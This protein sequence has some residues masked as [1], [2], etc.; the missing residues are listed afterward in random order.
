MKKS[1]LSL[2]LMGCLFSLSS[3]AQSGICGIYLTSNDYCINRLCY[4]HF[5]NKRTKPSDDDLLCSR[6]LLIDRDGKSFK[7]DQK[8]M[9][10]I[11]CSDGQI[12]RLYHDGHYI[13]LDP[14]EALLIYK[15]IAFPA[16]KGDCPK[17][18][19]YFSKDAASNVERLTLDNLRQAFT[20]NHKFEQAL[21]TQFRSDSDL[22]AYDQVHHRYKL[23]AAYSAND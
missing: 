15:V 23:I 10:A 21:D 16:A 20:D 11:A 1:S 17:T 6:H 2:L 13:L 12:I 14:G 22:C 8:D 3:A 9:Y 18:I 5:A 7:I 4:P 19:Y